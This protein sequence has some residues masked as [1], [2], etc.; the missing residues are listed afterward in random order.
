MTD[1]EELADN[2]LGRKINSIRSIKSLPFPA[3]EK[4]L[5]YLSSGFPVNRVEFPYCAACGHNFID[6]SPSNPTGNA[7]NKEMQRK[8]LKKMVKITAWR[9]NKKG[10]PWPVCPEIGKLLTK[11]STGV[12]E[13]A[14]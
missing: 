9:A 8:Y 12:D 4:E 11:V 14:H 5:K 10:L 6:H 2:E 7:E 1:N 3:E 13:E